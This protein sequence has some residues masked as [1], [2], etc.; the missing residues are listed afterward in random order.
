MLLFIHSTGWDW[1]YDLLSLC[2]IL[3]PS[4]DL[5]IHT[6]SVVNKDLYQNLCMQSVLRKNS[7]QC[8]IKYKL[9]F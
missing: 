7:N 8:F 3:H 1:S 4:L 6:S 9:N 2:Q 5:N